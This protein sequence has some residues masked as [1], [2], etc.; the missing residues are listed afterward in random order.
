MI[1]AIKELPSG[2]VWDHYCL[3]QDVPTGMSWMDSVRQYED[4]V[5]G[6]R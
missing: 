3:Q 6:K 2:A 5:T 1:E 4:E